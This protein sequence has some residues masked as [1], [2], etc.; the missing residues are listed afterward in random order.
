MIGL[1]RKFSAL[2]TLTFLLTIS[3]SLQ[4]KSSPNTPEGLEFFEKNVP[5]DSV[6]PFISTPVSEEE[7]PR[8]LNLVT[9]KLPQD[10]LFCH[11]FLKTLHKKN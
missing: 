9:N 7:I 10:A 11:S 8:A 4:I 5:T 3:F 1:V 2:K 6:K